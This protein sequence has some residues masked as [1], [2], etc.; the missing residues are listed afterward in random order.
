RQLDLLAVTDR[1]ADAEARRDAV[2]IARPSTQEQL[3]ALLE[4]RQQAE[5]E[6]SDAAGGRETALGALYSLQGVS[7]LAVLRRESATELEQ[8]LG[9]DLAEAER[10]AADR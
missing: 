6:L 7:E 1:P 9:G 5:D 10:A 4:E 2:V 3:T 8:R